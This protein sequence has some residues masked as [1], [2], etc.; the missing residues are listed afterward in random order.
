MND[1]YRF[2]VAAMDAL[3]FGNNC[4]FF[5]KLPRILVSENQNY[6]KSRTFELDQY[7]KNYY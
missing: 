5:F 6:L 2:K 7:R 3:F 1:L 4:I